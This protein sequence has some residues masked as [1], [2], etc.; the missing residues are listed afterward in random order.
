MLPISFL[1]RMFAQRS[2]VCAKPL[3]EKS[4]S[5]SATMYVVPFSDETVLANLRACASKT[6]QRSA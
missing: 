3:D 1:F 5:R 6:L 4:V 2:S